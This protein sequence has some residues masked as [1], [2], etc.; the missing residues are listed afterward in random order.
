M[1]A[2]FACLALVAVVGF[3]V[4]VAGSLTAVAPAGASIAVPVSITGTGLNATASNNEVS[5]APVGA[6]VRTALGEA[7]TTLDATRRRLTLRVPA[8]LPVGRVNLTVRNTVTGEQSAGVGFEVIEIHLAGTTAAAQGASGIPIRIAG[9][10]NVQFVAGQT[11][12]TF[13]AGVTVGAITVESA[14]SLVTTIAVSASATPGPRDITVKT[15]QQTSLL[16]GGFQITTPPPPNRSPVITSTPPLV[17]TEGAQYAYQALGTDPDGDTLAFRLVTAPQGMSITTG[18]VVSWTPS[19]TQTGSQ[20]VAIEVTDNRGGTDRQTFTIAVAPAVTLTGIT[21]SPN[22][23][24]F[25]ALESDRPLTVTGQM[26]N[27]S[28]V[29]LTAT[30]TAYES[31]NAFVAAVDALGVTRSVGNGSATITVRHGQFTG[32]AAVIVEAGVSL[33]ALTLSAP[34]TTL[35]S[36]GASLDVTLTGRFSDG[37]TRDLTTAEGTVYESADARIASVSS[38]GHVI[39]VA[40]GDVAIS[41]HHDVATATLVLHV[42]ISSG[43][44]ML[45]GQVLD[46]SKGLLLDGAT[47]RLLSDGGGSL[48]APVSTTT[49]DRGRFELQGRSGDAIVSITKPGFTTVER[50]AVIPAAAAVTLLDTR[51]TPFD[52]FENPIASAFGGD[53]RD[54]SALF[55]L[56]VPPGGI[57]STTDIRIT[58]ISGQGLEG[59]LPFGWS[60]VAASDIAPA[61]LSL[62]QPGTLT[63]PNAASLPAGA[64]VTIVAYDSLQHDWIVAGAARVSDDRRSIALPV[65][66]TGQIAGV[67]PDEAPFAPPAVSAGAV[68][69]G[70]AGV[71]LP[72]DVTASGE[73]LPRSAPPGD[74][75]RAIGH[76]LVGHGNT[77]PSGTVVQASVSER[78]ALSDQSQVVPRPFIEDIVLFTHGRPSGDGAVGASFPITPSRNYT[79]Q[80]LLQGVVSLDVAAPAA[81]VSSA[82][83]GATGGT[84]SDASGDSLDVPAAALGGDTIV[85]VTRVPSDKTAVAPPAGFDLISAVDVDFIGAAMTQPARLSTPAPANLSAADQLLLTMVFSDATGV[86]RLKLAGPAIL[87]GGRVISQSTSGAL[88]FPGVV[89]PAQYVFLRAQQPI[90]FIAGRAIGADG[91]TPRPRTLIASNTAP[92]ADLTP[93]TGRFIVAGRAGSDVVVSGIDAVTHDA[94]T[95][96]AHVDARDQIV[97]LDVTLAATAP[98]V[99][100]TNPSAHAINVPLDASVSIDFSDAID[101]AS[102]TA[103]R[104]VLQTG[105]AATDGQLTLSAD[106]RR[107]VFRPAAALD[108]KS[109]YTLSVADLRAVTGRALAAFTPVTFTT[110]DP[111][112]PTLGTSGL[113]TG[114]LPD[115]D[116]LVLVTG[117]PGAADASAPVTATNLRTQQTITVISSQDGSFRLRLSALIGDAITLTL[118][119]ASGR[120]TTISLSQLRSADGTTT[121]SER[122]GTILGAHGR[123]GTILPRALTQAGL[124]RLADAT[125]GAALPE[126]PAGFSVLDQFQFSSQAAQFNRLASLTLTED[127]NRFPP[128]SSASQ[129]FSAHGELTAPGDFLINAALHFTAVAVDVSGA[130]HTGSGSTTVVASG[131]DAS[132]A[133]GGQATE[134]PTVFVD[135]PRQAL[136]NQVVD[137]DAFAPAAR[138][139]LELPASPGAGDAKALLLVRLTTVGGEQK[140]SVVDVLS[141]A[142][143]DGAAVIRTS[144]RELRGMS[145]T[146]DYSV[147]GSAAPLVFVRGRLTGDAA[148]ATIEGSPFV[149]ETDGPNGTFILPVVAGQAFVAHFFTA[150]GG[151]LVGTSSGVAPATGT[152]DLGSP[153]A[154]PSSQVTVTVDPGA[155][156]IVDINQPI[157]FHFSE[158]VDGRTLSGGILVTDSAGSRVLGAVTLGADNA[159]ATFKP[160]RRWR[161][162]TTYRW[163]VA[164]TVI[165]VSGARL[166]QQASGEFTTFAPRVLGTSAIGV[167]HDVAVAGPLA[168]VATDAGA[169]V[170]DAGAAVNA[171][172]QAQVALP[173]GSRAAALLTD[174]SLTDRTGQTHD[175]P[176]A[177]I[178]SGGTAGTETLNLFDLSSPGAPVA[179]GSAQVAPAG[180]APAAIALTADRHAV[181]A[182]QGVGIASVSLADAVPADPANPARAVTARYPAGTVENVNQVALLGDRVLTAGAAGL[183]VLDATTL[184]RIGGISTTAD[185]RGVAALPAFSA[186]LNGDGIVSADTE[187][188]DLAAIANGADGT[189]QFYR[190]KASGDPELLSVVRFAGETT[191]VVLDADERLAYV[192]LGTRGMALVDLDGPASI[193]PIDLDRNGVDDRILGILDTPGEAER[194]ALALDRGLAFVA[195]GTAGLTTVQVLPPRVKVVTLKRDPVSAMVGDE[196][197]ILDTGVALSTDEALIVEL[198][199]VMAPGDKALIAVEQ[200]SA[201]RVFSFADGST[202]ANLQGGLNHLRIG[203]ARGAQPGTHAVL[204][205][206]DGKGVPIAS[207]DVTLAAPDPGAA[208]LNSLQVVP[209]AA[210]IG[211]GVSELD[212][213]VAG[214]FS[215]GK[216]RNLT[217][218]GT[219]TRYAVQ[220]TAVADVDA[221]GVVRPLGGGSSLVSAANQALTAFGS[222]TVDRAPVL[223]RLSSDPDSLTFRTAG[224]QGPAPIVGVLSD[225]SIVPASTVD[226]VTFATSDANVVSIDAQGNLTAVA[227]GLATISASSGSLRADV[228]VDDDF[229]RPASITSLALDAP[230]GTLTQDNGPLLIQARAIGTG[231]L[232]GL[233]VVFTLSGSLSTSVSEITN[234]AGGATIEIPALASSGSVGVSASVI[235]PSTGATRTATGSLTIAAPSG[236][237]EPNNDPSSASPIGGGQIVQGHLDAASDT[238]DSYRLTTVADGVVT[239]TLTLDRSATPAN[240][241]LVFRSASGQEIARV[242][243]TDLVTQLRQPLP[244]G[245]A[246]ISVETSGGAFDYQLSVETVQADLAIGSVSPASAPPGSAVTISGTGFSTAADATT[247]LFGGIAGK[248]VTVSSTQINVLVPANAVNGALE[249]ISGDRRATVPGFSVGN[250]QPRPAAFTQPRNPSS[251]R[252]DPISGVVLDITRVVVTA[253][254]LASLTQMTALA[255]GLGGTISGFIPSTHT[256][257]MTFAANSAFDGLMALIRQLQ[258]S[259]LV[260][261]ADRS[262]LETAS[263]RALDTLD[264]SGN[265]PNSNVPLNRWF[266]VIQ[267]G[268]AIDA[269]RTTVPFDQRGGLHGVTPAVIDDG[270]SPAFLQAEFS[271]NGNNVVTALAMT[272]GGFQ[273]AS[274]PSTST[275]GAHGTPVSSII[276]EP[277]NGVTVSGI[278]NSLVQPNEDPYRLLVYNAG[279]NGGIDPEAAWAALDHIASRSDVPVVNMSFGS[280]LPNDKALFKERFKKYREHLLLL[281]GKTLAVISAGNDNVRADY[282]VPAVLSR[283]MGNV[284]SVGATAVANADGTG[285][286]E[287]ARA[288]FGNSV[289][290]FKRGNVACGAKSHLISGSN[291]GP[292]VSIAAPGEDILAADSAVALKPF[293]GTSAAAPVVAGVAALVQTIRQNDPFL[294]PDVV[295][296]LLISTADDISDR[297]NPGRMVRVN[298]FRAVNTILSGGGPA[299]FFVSDNEVPMPNGTGGVVSVAIDPLT[300]TPTTL[301]TR[302][303]AIDLTVAAGSTPVHPHH[304]TTVIVSPAGE[305]LYVVAKSDAT[306]GDGIAVIDT[307]ALKARTFIPL[308]GASLTT[309]PGQP[310]PTAVQIDSTKPGLALSKDGRLLYVAANDRIIIVNTESSAVVTQF[311]DMPRAYRSRAK[312]LPGV[313]ENRLLTV[314]Q[315]AAQF[316]AGIQPGGTATFA[317]LTVSADGRTLLA[318][319]QVGRGG[320]KQPGFVLPINVDLYLDPGIRLDDYFVAGTPHSMLPLGNFLEGD[321]P[322]D[323]AASPTGKQAYLLNGGVDAYEGV[324]NRAL[325]LTPYAQ[326]LSGGVLGAVGS[327]SGLLGLEAS[328]A[329]FAT[330]QASLYNELLLDL[331]VQSDSGITL[332][333]APGVTGVFEVANVG[334]VAPPEWAFPSEVVFGWNPPPDNGGRIVNQFSFPNLFAKRPF[335]ISIRPDGKRA[336]ISFFQTGN[337]GLLDLDA[338]HRFT[339][340]SVAGLSSDLFQGLVAVTP[341]VKL[342]SHLWPSRGAFTAGGITVPSPDESLLFAGP[343]VYA[344]NGKFAVGVHTGNSPPEV[345][346]ATLPDFAHD[347]LSRLR[348]NEIGFSVAPGADT[349]TDPNGESIASFQPYEFTRGGGAVTVLRDAPMTSALTANASL[350]VAGDNG[351]ARPYYTENPLCATPDGTVPRCLDDVF[352]HLFDYPTSNGPIPFYR[353]R[354]IA[355]QPFVAFQSPRF[356]DTVGRTTAMLVRWRHASGTSVHVDAVDLDA[357]AGGTRVG[358]FDRPLTPVEMLSQSIQL[359][360]RSLV[361]LP[362]DGHHYRVSVAINVEAGTDEAE[363]A[364]ASIDVTFKARP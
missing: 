322:S 50:R 175:G 139:D 7:I 152:L 141:A 165:A 306:L 144:G 46:D 1:V 315:V 83:V 53:A 69:S 29:D 30:E 103:G 223:T 291:C 41:A 35:R 288:D 186:D 74:Q 55:H 201:S 269:I 120:D 333:S 270:F 92:F 245:A 127:Q 206:Q 185:A 231:S 20:S 61:G 337:F 305:S 228:A 18:G 169:A 224:A 172:P 349:G 177:M 82:L 320:G 283:T 111:S 49:D 241:T 290:G 149:F 351:T 153:L 119:D 184:A 222:I 76:L 266:D 204:R 87:Q 193:Q 78:F 332:I 210:T 254:P 23:L 56:V 156:Q 43:T 336:L 187:S 281:S 162:A 207:I 345:I 250:S 247:V 312:L 314:P 279:S 99:T 40:P 233:S 257:V 143:H 285:E 299:S 19:S 347:N 358:G 215:D 286:G 260:V 197:S 9:S 94:G 330:T 232:D 313:L 261:S 284:I 80:E 363:L 101:A 180:G 354:G 121:V 70:I 133:E 12:V 123:V 265:W 240:V 112:K 339:S 248:L 253:D 135:A 142:D 48:S 276:I 155:Q 343:I 251:L 16:S 303:A 59:R 362:V 44:G 170:L 10:S 68:L 164:T 317:A 199:A 319:V 148:I 102:I 150:T 294:Q 130:R 205:T 310:H 221:D 84:A 225:G 113:V 292:A 272:G 126:L 90:G 196:E 258:A 47:V 301:A 166:T 274:N 151:V 179:I 183:T 93:A 218:A 106:R 273:P 85:D 198:Q 192:A 304:P 341:S 105:G 329:A 327:S 115:E 236:D 326:I 353:P 203:I 237:N 308:S 72:A 208:T 89:V 66:V 161:F 360:F 264:M 181:V 132:L 300:G 278:L 5:F 31:T 108:G 86:L 42:V 178:G 63:I 54:R 226:G 182:V 167:A 364:T 259:P 190:V 38:A 213:S 229:R 104:V 100:A 45:R 217:T 271:V 22:F 71:M 32:S 220:K 64:E 244:A 293:G 110:I 27:G 295:R 114:D 145:S 8:G 287:D 209:D 214:F 77:L 96:G 356:A 311:L 62:G 124:F 321:E 163:G 200:V 37:E 147:V 117:G 21:V 282:Q 88:A 60:P 73:V 160:S 81:G 137:V 234:I 256:Y 346:D 107:L 13:G 122:G 230:S 65:N 361:P 331:K 255:A 116:G 171:V 173:N 168:V 249:V 242:T 296:Q 211:A 195:D 344:Q 136:Q 212:L 51:L 298:A 325:D 131:A 157:T 154:P 158:P 302:V 52:T 318:A 355:I 277:N 267:A 3:A 243:V 91:T 118:R 140:L 97:A 246:S 307:R 129:P 24:R 95:G 125:A 28:S 239:I 289:P 316:A 138:V 324:Q 263:A 79:I 36:I 238:A 359:T 11:S 188:L 128:Q 15:S 335:G 338:Q 67:V 146:G 109:L 219:G 202:V 334:D 309:A 57:A 159:T 26:S 14:T 98:S 75:A 25:G 176:I 235:D 33:D 323:I 342:D 174:V 262:I 194:I 328:L 350:T 275:P 268:E 58:P 2:V 297:W 216:V 4:V 191:G 189:L 340:P 227:E 17:A 352:S 252:R 348:L 134:F 34:T 39:A 6:A 280:N 357:S